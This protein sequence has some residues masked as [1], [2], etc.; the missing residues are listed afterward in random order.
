MTKEE[1]LLLFSEFV[2]QHLDNDIMRTDADK[3]HSMSINASKIRRRVVVD[4]ELIWITASSEQEYAEKLVEVLGTKKIKKKS[5]TKF[6]DY[7]IRWFE[8]FSKPNIAEVTAIS[9]SRQLTNNILPV[10]KNMDIANI[11]PADIQ[12]V[13]NNMGN[14]KQETK[15]KT[16][17]VLS[18]IFK[19]AVEDNLITVNPMLSSSLRIRGQKANET[20]PYTVDQMKYLAAH[21]CDLKNKYDK[22]WLALS[23]AL[24][25]RPEE[26]LGLT[27][28]DYK[29]GKVYIHNTVT[30]PTRNQPVFKPYTKTASSV[31]TL[32][33]PKEIIDA[34]PPRGKDNEFIVG[35]KEPLSYTQLRR[36]RQRIAKQT[37]FTDEI[38]P[39]RFRTTVATDI[40]AT[41]HDLKLVQRMLGHST[42]QMT[43]K[44]YDKGRNDASDASSAIGNCYGF[45][46]M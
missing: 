28:A 19:M 21:L 43:L 22:A 8:V 16:K 23:I 42:P 25:L 5:G 14:V 26:V 13:F 34:L 36:M 37:G 18:Q 33:L 39:R 24:P 4:G 11:T 10:L 44:H 46:S 9:Y 29:D 15:N 6:G 12:K 31:R 2:D 40:S 1:L 7:A 38:V 27:W 30:H 35:G 17:I 3:E 32:V 20:Q 45:S 41:T